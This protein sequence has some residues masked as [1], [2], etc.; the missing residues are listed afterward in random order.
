MRICA[1]SRC[2]ANRDIL[3]FR[4]QLSHQD[5]HLPRSNRARIVGL[6]FQARVESA[7]GDGIANASLPYVLQRD[8]EGR[9][10]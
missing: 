6:L 10:G 2:L 4:F 1:A 5:M 3:V 9:A 7:S 8:I